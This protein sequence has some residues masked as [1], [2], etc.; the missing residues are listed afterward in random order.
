MW[1]ILEGATLGPPFIALWC[2]D[3]P[4]KHGS[5]ISFPR[6]PT[7]AHVL[8]TLSSKVEGTRTLFSTAFI[9]I[10]NF[11]CLILIFLVL[12]F[13]QEDRN[14]IALSP[15]PWTIL[16]HLNGSSINIC[17][18][19]N[20]LNEMRNE[21]SNGCLTEVPAETYTLIISHHRKCRGKLLLVG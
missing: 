10:W 3:S 21:K 17:Q 4:D 18:I 1:G 9:P 13:L 16:T 12:A 8:A 6:S 19:N 14:T 2:A 5:S 7:S 15:A 20:L 11:L